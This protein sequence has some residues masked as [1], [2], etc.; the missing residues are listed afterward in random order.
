MMAPLPF[1]RLPT[2]RLHAFDHSAI[3]VA[4]PYNV[5]KEKMEGEGVDEKLPV[6]RWVLVIHCATVGAVYLEMMDMMDTESFLLAIE[7]FLRPTVFLA[8]NGTNF[9]GRDNVLGRKK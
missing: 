2:A 7:Q 6:K 1:F 9:H 4:G 8:H 3:D 5:I